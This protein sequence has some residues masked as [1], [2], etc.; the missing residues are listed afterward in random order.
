MSVL[1]QVFSRFL[2]LKLVREKFTLLKQVLWRNMQGFVS[3]N[4][5]YVCCSFIETVDSDRLFRNL[6]KR[7]MLAIVLRS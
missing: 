2:L 7:I 6:S 5:I 3:M 1:V 4:K